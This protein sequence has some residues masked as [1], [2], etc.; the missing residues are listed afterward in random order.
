M[1]K[2]EN[3][4]SVIKFPQQPNGK[5]LSHNDMLLVNFSA[6]TITSLFF[7]ICLTGIK[8]CVKVNSS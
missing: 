3:T 6:F 8:D 5:N 7:S 1:A 2:W 4:I